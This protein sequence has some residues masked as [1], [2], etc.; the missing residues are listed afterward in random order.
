M[1]LS[2]FRISVDDSLNFSTL[3]NSPYL[4]FVRSSGLVSLHFFAPN[5][6]GHQVFYFDP[7]VFIDAFNNAKFKRSTPKSEYVDFDTLFFT[8]NY[9]KTPQ[10]VRQIFSL[11]IINPS[12]I[13]SVIKSHKRINL[14]KPCRTTCLRFIH[15]PR[16]R[17]S[18]S[19]S[20]KPINQSLLDDALYNM[21]LAVSKAAAAHDLNKFFPFYLQAYKDS[22]SAQNRSPYLS[23][24]QV[25]KLI[26]VFS[27]LVVDY[28]S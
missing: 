19:S 23:P 17:S 21:N 3:D 10:F 25:D 13:R 2:D 18:S 12:V 4:Y 16:F 8:F 5:N 11:F 9:P 14:L 22:L 27:K 6:Q 20:P 26:S 1:F 7:Q 15:S 28:S 24:K